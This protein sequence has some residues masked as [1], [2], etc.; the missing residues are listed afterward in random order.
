V[1][2]YNLL[3]GVSDEVLEHF[4][5]CS[6]N[7]TVLVDVGFP[8]LSK[9]N[10]FKLSSSE[11]LILNWS[12]AEEDDGKHLRCMARARSSGV[13]LVISGE[14]PEA[15]DE[16]IE[17]FLGFALASDDLVKRVDESG[18]NSH[19]RSSSN[20]FNEFIDG[21]KLVFLSVVD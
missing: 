8:W 9:A 12:I 19:G 4:D 7:R 5:V 15:R 2:G 3:V 14:S 1:H 20:Q 10:Q 6:D 17:S 18:D 11:G 16:C 13:H 21:T